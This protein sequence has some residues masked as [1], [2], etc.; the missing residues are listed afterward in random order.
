MD[1]RPRLDDRLVRPETREEM[2]R[3]RRVLAMPAKPEHGDQ[4][5]KLDYVIGAHVKEGY[6]GSTDMLTRLSQGSDF[7]T[8]TC[9][10]RQGKDEKTGERYLE[11]LAFEVVNEQSLR[12]MT[13]RAEDLTARGVRRVVA[14][15]AKRQEVREW[16]AELD[17]WRVL[18]P[19]GTLDDPTLAQPIPI[20]ALLD[21]AEA[22]RAVVQA[23]YAK[24]A[25]ALLAIEAKGL[26]HGL[27][28]GITAL[29]SALAIALDAD[30]RA[31]L[32]ALDAEGLEALLATLGRERRWP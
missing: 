15:F 29:C 25:P 21:R 16:S 24:R 10:R 13:E 12:D 6:V 19:S 9:V 26:R 20:R 31:A 22:D 18:D 3:G 28:Q 30:R 14:I 23:L 1:P 17:D 8:D 5:F 11:E 27:V 2:V 7:A 4:H 32:Q